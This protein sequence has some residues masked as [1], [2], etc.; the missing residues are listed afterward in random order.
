MHQLFMAQFSCT[1]I[2]LRPMILLLLVANLRVM[3]QLV[4]F[5]SVP[6]LIKDRGDGVK[7]SER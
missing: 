7:Q 5:V 3:I 4:L 1:V 2:R 6:N